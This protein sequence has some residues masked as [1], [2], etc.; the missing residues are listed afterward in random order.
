MSSL[1]LGSET[2]LSDSKFFT[3][4]CFQ[5]TFKERQF[6][7]YG[8][9]AYRKDSEEEVKIVQLLNFKAYYLSFTKMSQINQSIS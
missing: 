5:H 4:I 8:V 1:M 6:Q 9:I 3:V 2:F 7:L